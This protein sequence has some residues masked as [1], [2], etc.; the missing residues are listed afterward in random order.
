[1]IRIRESFGAKVLAALLGTVGL[2]LT[3]TFLVVRVQ[4]GR[5]VEEV[6]ERTIRNASALFAELDELQRQQTAQLTGRFTGGMRALAMLDAAISAGDVETLA[7]EVDYEMLLADLDDVL[8]VFTDHAGAPVLSM[9]A[10][11]RIVGGDPAN[12]LPLAEALIA[13]GE[14]ESAGYRMVDG[15]LY[16]VRSLYIELQFRPIGTITFGLPITP[17]DVEGIGSIGGFEVCFFADGSCVVRTP[18]VDAELEASMA[19]AVGLADAVRADAGGIEYSI[20][21]EQLSADHPEEGARIVAVPLDAVVAPFDAIERA[22]LLGGVGAL[23]LSGLLGAALSRSLTRPIRDLVRATGRIAEGDY[24]AEVRVTS[25]DEMG[26]LA[27]A[28]NEMTRGL[29]LRERYRSVLNKVVSHGIAEELM[30]GDVEL[31]GEN[32]EVSVLFADLRGFTPLTE[33]ME[34]QQVI[35]LLNECME[36]LSQAVDAEGGVVDKFIGDEIMAVFGAPAT[37]ADHAGRAVRAAVGMRTGIAVMNAKRAG[38]GLPPLA[39]GIGIASGVAV[40]GNMGS[41]DRLNYTVLGRIVNL[42]ARLTDLAKPGQILVSDATMADARDLVETT[43]LGPQALKG[44]STG[45]EVFCV[46]SLRA[47]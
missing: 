6:T 41:T 29:A 34:P 40:A 38:R 27:N 3:V 31:G 2:L 15:R 44:F 36:H 43:C 8:L 28:F 46:E 7:N 30:K 22:L 39:V 19:S 37:Q 4:T 42:A 17:E 11:E 20:R 23:L 33:G 14:D 24:E 35:A 13:T 5:E 26:T 10:G 18:G 21:A 9:V 45:V 25:H 12:V 47:G 32:R 1:V 16:S